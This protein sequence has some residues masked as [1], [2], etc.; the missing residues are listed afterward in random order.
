MTRRRPNPD[1]ARRWSFGLG[2][3]RRRRDQLARNADDEALIRITPE[4]NEAYQAPRRG[5][6]LLEMLILAF[7]AVFVWRFWTLQVEQGAEFARQAQNNRWRAEKV[8]APRGRIFDV[9][10]RVLAD[11]RTTY[12][13]SLVRD[14]VQDLT[15]TLAQVSVW[16]GRDV[17]R[18]RERY[19][20]LQYKVKSF[21]PLL[22]VE[23]IDFDL[24]ARIES[25]LWAWPGLE[26][27]IL[28]RRSYPEK[29]L[30]AHILGYVA[31]ANEKELEKD[32]EL[33][34]GDLIGKAGIELTMDKRLRGRKGVYDIEVDASGHMV[35]RELKE[36]PRTGVDLKLALDMDL[37]KACWDALG[38]QA[39]SV[40]VMEPET[41]KL[42]AMVTAPAYDNNLFARGISH[43]DWDEL[44]N[45]PRFPLQNRTIQSVYPPGSVWKLLM[46]ACFLE[47]GISPNE[48]VNCPGYA[49]LGNQ[50]FRCWLHSGH[51]SQNLESALMNSCDVYFYIIAE[52]VGINKIEKFARACGFGEKTGIDLP[53]EKSGLVPSRD[54]KQKRHKEAWTRGD[55]YNTS[56]GQG[57]TLTT[58]IQIAVY[59]GGLLNGGK[60]LK[61]LLI[62]TDEPEVQL[63]IP[64][65]P[66]TLD[67]VVYA[68]QR[69]ASAG[70]ARV[71]GRKDAVMGG[72]TGTAQ[73]V[74]LGKVKRPNSELAWKER[75]HAWIA[76]WGKKNGR[77]YVVVVMV[78]HGG[79]GSSVAGPVAKKVYDFLFAEPAA[80]GT[81]RAEA[82]APPKARKTA[83]AAPANASRN[84]AAARA[85][86]ERNGGQG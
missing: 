44:R 54:W 23:D 64:A 29:D 20:Q 15:S 50:T 9:D 19:R 60:I 18:V 76:T 48:R 10:G 1:K 14:D 33:G 59:V 53:H 74:K 75:D 61:P 58:P 62:D 7:V 57:F 41:G 42:R 30:L 3:R 22:L 77:S 52:K 12:G 21:E 71:V 36:E 63:E 11:N 80:P 66:E 55:T 26:I 17:E 16:T 43:K 39:G 34:M 27:V 47:N 72:K 32:P 2:L 73:V 83:P 6:I 84:Q 38:E 85:A 31:E 68:M 49:K 70:T 86:D 28:S 69:T 67:R 37:Q 46:A 4:N 40:V 5:V 13:L 45:S 82:T 24:T 56:I 8:T 51:G 25:E 79:G 81:A 35:S 78:E 65:R